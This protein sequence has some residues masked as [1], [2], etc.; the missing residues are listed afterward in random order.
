[1]RMAF[2]PHGITEFDLHTIETKRLRYD[3]GE[4]GLLREAL[5]RAISRHRHLT[6]T[7][8]GTTD[9]L[10]PSN[11]EEGI[12]DE[13]KQQVGTLAGMVKSAPELSWH[14]GIG[15]QLDWA[16]DRLWL[17]LEPRTVFKGLTGLNRSVAADFARE[18]TV[19]RYNRQ[20]NALIAFWARQIAGDGVEMRALGIGDGVDAVFK[21]SGDTA[22]SKRSG[23]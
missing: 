11:M 14:E 6:A 17:L 3:S 19:R 16:D 13:L 10:V 7:R 22:Y 4:R 12:W 21:I 18:R 15:I 8:Y 2:Q 20:L 23:A 9:L 5:T 1:M